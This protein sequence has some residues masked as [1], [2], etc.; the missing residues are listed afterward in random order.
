MTAAIAETGV[1]LSVGVPVFQEETA[2]PLFLDAIIPIL[3]IAAPNYEILVCLCLGRDRASE[4]HNAH[5][6]EH[7]L[8]RVLVFSRC[9][10]QPSGIIAVIDHYNHD[11]SG[12]ECFVR[13]L[14]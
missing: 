4:I 11:E 5:D 7:S 9:F 1:E 6:K 13:F 14:V 10:G 12:S 2:I 3:A 8:I